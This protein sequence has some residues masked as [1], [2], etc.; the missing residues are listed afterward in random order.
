MLRPRRIWGGGVLV[1]IPTG[2]AAPAHAVIFV[3]LLKIVS[4]CTV[5][6]YVAASERHLLRGC[7]TAYMKVFYC[8]R[9][10]YKTNYETYV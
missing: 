2:R 9:A 6:N 5:H 7:A 10:D 8:L 4:V 3:E 1:A